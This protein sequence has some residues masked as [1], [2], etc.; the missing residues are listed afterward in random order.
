MN[1]KT[2]RLYITTTLSF[3]GLVIGWETSGNNVDPNSK[4]EPNV[5]GKA[6]CGEDNGKI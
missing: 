3:V 4:R 6:D 2:K 1:T 5:V